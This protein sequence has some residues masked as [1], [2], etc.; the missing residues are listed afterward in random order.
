MTRAPQP[1]DLAIIGASFAGLAAAKTAAMRGLKV[2]VLDAK[3]GAGDRA[4]QPAFW[5]RKPPRSS[6]FPIAS[7]GACMAC[8]FMRPT[9][10]MRIY[11]RPAAFFS[12]PSRAAF[13]IGWPRKRCG[14][15]R[16]SCGARPSRALGMRA[17]FSLFR[18]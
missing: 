12:P 7:P 13:S 18:A 6:T 2:A 4:A 1:Y 14:Q 3:P 8:G 11:S 17:A 15:A 5:S 9:L 16:I 10:S